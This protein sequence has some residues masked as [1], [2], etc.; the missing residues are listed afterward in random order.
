VA[1]ALKRLVSRMHGELAR[2]SRNS[3]HVVA[4]RSHHE[5]P[6]R[7]RG[8]PEV[9]VSAVR[10]VLRAVRDGARL[11]PCPR[12]FSGPDVRCR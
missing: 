12:I 9:V 2:L 8:Q 6:T 10:A 11:A 7:S 3:L 4:L 5:V 1:S